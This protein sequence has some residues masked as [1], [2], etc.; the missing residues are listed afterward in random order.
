MIRSLLLWLTVPWVVMGVGLTSGNVSNIAD[1]FYPRTG[2]LFVIAWWASLWI[3]ILIFS[4]WL[5]F[6]S[7][8]EKLIKYPGFLRANATNPGTIKLIY[9][10]TLFSNVVVT[11][12]IFSLEKK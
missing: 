6:Q 12:I 2:N 1:Y 7:G 10:L 3:L 4:V 11:V 5:W 9:L 8:A